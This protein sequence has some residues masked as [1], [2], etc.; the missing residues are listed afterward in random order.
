MLLKNSLK[1]GK[2]QMSKKILFLVNLFFLCICFSCT[3]I[4]IQYDKGYVIGRTFDFAFPANAQLKFYPQNTALETTTINKQKKEYGF[5]QYIFGGFFA[6]GQEKML[7]DGINEKGLLSSVLWMDDATYDTGE[8]REIERDESK[9][10]FYLDVQFLVLGNCQTIAEV[11]A[12]LKDKKIWGEGVAFSEN[13]TKNYILFPKIHFVFYDASGKSIIVEIKK[14]KCYFYDNQYGVLANEPEY[15]WHLQNMEQYRHLTNKTKKSKRKLPFASTVS[16]NGLVGLP[17]DH[18]SSGRFVRI[19]INKYF[20]EQKKYNL[21]ESIVLADRLLS[22]VVIP[23]N[24]KLRFQYNSQKIET[25][26]QM[27]TLTR[28]CLIKDQENFIWY[29]KGENDINY[30]KYDIRSFMF[31]NKSDS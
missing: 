19:A 17:G 7:C 25:P 15:K 16:G 4:L 14:G 3:E 1:R 10:I 28:Y 26:N 12:F 2:T 31:E 5:S 6:F 24:T 8:T 23:E 20:S 30:T 9:S 13:T 29:L 21:N 27:P 11:R 22:A 18:S